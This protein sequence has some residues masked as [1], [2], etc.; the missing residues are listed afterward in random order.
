[1]NMTD[2]FSENCDSGCEGGL[3]FALIVLGVPT[4]VGIYSCS[5]VC[6]NDIRSYL[7]KRRTRRRVVVFENKLTPKYI[8]E[9]NSNFKDGVINSECSICLAEVKSSKK[10]TVSLPCHHA[11]HEKCL[12][13]WVKP[14]VSQ[15]IEPGC[16]ICR[17]IIVKRRVASINYDDHEEFE[18]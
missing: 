4:I 11:F 13:E 3:L 18:V 12:Q 6:Y 16:P 8:K 2:S 15:G 17:K 9:L 1:M 5:C 10:K 14:N 7:R